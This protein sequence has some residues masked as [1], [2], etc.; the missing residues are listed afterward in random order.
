MNLHLGKLAQERRLHP[1]IFGG[2]FLLAFLMRLVFLGEK[3]IYVDEAVT[4]Y[5]SSRPLKDILPFM[6]LIKEV[7][8]PIYFWMVG[9]WMK[10]YPYFSHYFSFEAFLRFSSVFFGSLSVAMTYLLSKKLFNKR[11]ALLSSFF[12]AI[13]TFHIYYSQELRMYPLLLFLYLAS[14]YSFFKLIEEGTLLWGILY[15][16]ATS[17][18]LLTHYYAFY[19]LFIEAA[20]WGG[21]LYKEW[22]EN[23]GKCDELLKGFKRW[24]FYFGISCIPFLFWIPNFLSQMKFQ[25][26]KIRI[27]P[28]IKS[29]F[30]LFSRIAYG[31]NL[32]HP[33][34]GKVDVYM[35]LSIVPLLL[36]GFFLIKAKGK[37]KIFTALYLLSPIFITFLVT[38]SSFHIFEYKYFFVTIPAFWMAISYSL[39]NIPAKLSKPLAL[40]L[41]LMNL[42]TGWNYQSNPF[43]QAQNWKGA[44]FFVK[45]YS[46]ANQK[47]IVHP[48]MMALP[49]IYYYGDKGVVP[50][51]KFDYSRVKGMEKYGGWLV[52]TFYH[53]FVKRANL[54]PNLEKSFKI[55]EVA[56]FKSYN[57]ANVI[58]I[59]L[60]LPRRNEEGNRRSK[61]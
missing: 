58:K 32:I 21:V 15:V 50:M 45:K 19:I 26:F 1:L 14:F 33:H 46:K 10:V 4:I 56:K 38:F 27:N 8:P 23:R 49:F 6:M 44:A 36:I 22:K 54:I 12:M 60:L 5:I 48:S 37:G 55:T 7:H 42:Y 29:F 61:N 25:D 57:K 43:Y 20:F 39:D 9:A 16:L 24:I 47:I 11:I 3:S 28:S 17:S 53:P 18:A 2:V 41:I 52:T 31:D 59:Y 34:I 13:S 40:F 35:I 30:Y 51:D